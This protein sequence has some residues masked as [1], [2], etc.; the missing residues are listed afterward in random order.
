MAQAP[1]IR[2]DEHAQSAHDLKRFGHTHKEIAAYIGIDEKT[3]VKYYGEVLDKAV[4]DANRKVSNVLFK[5]AVQDEDM[6]AVIFYLKTKGGWKTADKMQ[7]TESTEALTE[8]IRRLRAQ[9]DEKNKKD[10]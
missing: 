1:H 9:I 3:L 10:Y 5:K 4:P 8:E 2:T 7:E 6:A